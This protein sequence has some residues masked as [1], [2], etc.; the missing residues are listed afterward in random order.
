MEY[1]DKRPINLKYKCIVDSILVS[2]MVISPIIIGAKFIFL[3]EGSDITALVIT[4]IWVTSIIC[5]THTI[6]NPKW[7]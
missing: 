1:D 4:V 6:N 2:V 5:S 7:R 3:K